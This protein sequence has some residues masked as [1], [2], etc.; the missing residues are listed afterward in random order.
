MTSPIPVRLLPVVMLGLFV[1][2]AANVCL[3]QDGGAVPSPQTPGQGNTGGQRGGGQPNTPSPG[4]G[5]SQREPRFNEPEQRILYLS[6]Q[7]KLLDGTVPPDRVVIE[8]VCGGSV[9]PEGYT[10][11]KGN[12]S[13]QVG[14]RNSNVF[15]D[16]S[17]ASDFRLEGARG[18]NERELAGC[19]IRANLAGFISE[20]I[21]LGFRHALDDPDIGI[22]R[23]RPLANVEGFTFSI[24]SAMAPK[25]ARKAYENGS[26]K[27]QKGRWAEAEK[28]LVKAVKSFPK[29]AIAWFD[30]GYAYQKQQKL[31]EA[32]KAY[33]Q[34]LQADSK[35]VNPYG[36]L[37]YLSL[38][39]SKWDDAL[40]YASRM[41]KLNPY[42]GA[43]VYLY[44]AIANYNLGKADV[45]EE[46]AR[47]AAKIDS[48]RKIAKIHHL[49]GVILKDKKDYAGAAE[50]LRLYLKL[51]PKAPDASAVKQDLEE[52]DRN[53]GAA[54]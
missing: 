5:N 42:V 49:L 6:G 25:D 26:E 3:A 4:Q 18:V 8:R 51:N 13:F 23:L 46:H 45:A 40:D 24:T 7:V 9:R 28:E 30:L 44:S 38:S 10:D 36:Q 33:H 2:I 27:I 41:L 52:I 15:M 53:L 19:E 35:F 11:S 20:S 50:S 16:A 1:L 29:Y 21:S 47:Q 54:K 39:Q 12:F 31:D 14:G 43:D 37:A 32:S 17:V 48:D 22:I 34:A